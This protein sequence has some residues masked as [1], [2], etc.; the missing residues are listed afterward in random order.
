MVGQRARQALGVGAPLLEG[1]LGLLGGDVQLARLVF[2]GGVLG[3]DLGDL[4]HVP[5]AERAR[6]GLDQGA[7]DGGLLPVLGGRGAGVTP[8]L[9][10]LPVRLGGGA[11]RPVEAV[12]V[13]AAS[14]APGRGDLLVQGFT[15]LALLHAL[16]RRLQ[17]LHVPLCGAQSA[18]A[19]VVPRRQCG[20][21]AAQALQG[22]GAIL[23][24]DLQ[25]PLALGGRQRLVARLGG[26]GGS[27]VDGF[28]FCPQRR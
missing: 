6:L 7:L 11:L 3:D 28:G 12:G 25:V 9:H 27:L 23:D 18:V 26:R 22:A 24:L 16:H 21:F 20:L 5:P 13:G 17:L 4:R 19:H 10:R 15:A 2:E 1:V 14:L 8:A